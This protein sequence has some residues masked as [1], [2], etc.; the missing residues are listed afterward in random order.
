MLSNKIIS[1]RSFF[2]RVIA[3]AAGAA[4]GQLLMFTALPVLV[5]VFDPEV[6]GNLGIFTSVVS[7]A[8][9]IAALRFD[10]AISA[11]LDESAANTAFIASLFCAL[12]TSVVLYLLLSLSASLEFQSAVHSVS[13]LS[14]T[15]M[16]ASWSSAMRWYLLRRG[17]TRLI[18]FAHV[19]RGL[20]GAAFQ[21]STALT[22]AT[23][24]G[25][26]LGQA[27]YLCFEVVILGPAIIRIAVKDKFKFSRKKTTATL[28]ANWRYPVFSVPE[29]LMD[30]AG[31]NLPLIIIGIL[32]GADVA[33]LFFVAKRALAAPTTLVG[34]SVARIYMA[35]G[36][37]RKK[38]GELGIFTRRL[39]LRLYGGAMPVVLLV[40]LCCQLDISGFVGEAWLEISDIVLWLL[41][42]VFIQFGCSPVSTVLHLQNRQKVAAGIQL[43]GLTLQTVPLFIA[44]LLSSQTPILV[45]A[46]AASVYYLVYALT[47]LRA[48]F[49]VESVCVG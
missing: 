7:M 25:L 34:M 43:L 14:L 33:G 5:N 15:V 26:V 49:R 22:V 20:V 47:V 19:A 11:Q 9:P 3:L 8:V 4:T 30:S 16:L 38:K 29:A 40:A 1:T 23:Y 2:G 18:S 28:K 44:S 24:L 37:E 21:V 27:L 39:M 46:V 42:V 10:L 35:E 12:V 36:A 17:A 13:V 48:S 41:P 6:L 32:W 45:Y 31:N